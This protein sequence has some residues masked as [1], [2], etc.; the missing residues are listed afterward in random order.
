MSVIGLSKH[1][2]TKQL[3]FPQ[4][5]L[6]TFYVQAEASGPCEDVTNVVEALAQMPEW[7]LKS[8]NANQYAGIASCEE[9]VKVSSCQLN[10]VKDLCPQTCEAG[11]A[12][13]NSS[14]HIHNRRDFRKCIVP[15]YSPTALCV[16]TNGFKA[17]LDGDF[18]D[19]YSN[20]TEN[21]GKVLLGAKISRFT[22]GRV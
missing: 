7:M 20:D 5:T 4:R 9:L 2:H 18:C 16:D 13:G 8:M 19:A 14:P 15:L 21:P 11:C 3:S 6:S 12:K 17:N 10:M 1:M 22:I